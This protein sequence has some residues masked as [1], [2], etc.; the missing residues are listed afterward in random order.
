MYSFVN[1]VHTGIQN[2][3]DFTDGAYVQRVMDAAYRSAEQKREISI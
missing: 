3:P 1:A 2:H